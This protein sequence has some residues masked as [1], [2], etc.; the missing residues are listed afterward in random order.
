[1]PQ[2]GK[3]RTAVVRSVL[4]AASVSCW[5]AA[6]AAQTPYNI[7]VPVDK[8]S[9]IFT[10]LFGPEGL[11]VDSQALLP[12]EQPHTAHFNSDFQSEFSQFSTALTSQLV[13]VPL[14]SPA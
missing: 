6:A 10:Q 4:L 11:K 13:T 9:L 5:P 2:R 7:A 12:G 3:K 14:P 8:L 1:M